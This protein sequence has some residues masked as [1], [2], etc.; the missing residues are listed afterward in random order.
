MKCANHF[1]KEAITKCNLCAKPLCDECVVKLHEESYCR[2]CSTAKTGA[3]SGV[4]KQEHSPAL[5]AIL[6]FIIAGLGQMYNGQVWKGLFVFLTSLLV[7]PWVFGIFD[8]YFVAKKIASGERELKKKTGCLIAMIIWVFVSWVMIF[9]LA[10]LAAIV[11]PNLLRARM[12]TDEKSVV[13]TLQS[14]SSAFESYAAQNN[15]IYTL[16]EETLITTQPQYLPA[17]YNNRTLYGYKLT[18]TLRTSGYS[19]KAEPV[20]CLPGGKIFIMETGGKLSQ[21]ECRPSKDNG[22]DKE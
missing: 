21:E 10:L 19:I 14:I 22:A 8:A 7:I 12:I 13:S 20:T 9:V 17:A 6:S 18:E 11:I 3:I 5:A 2:P 4:K 16:S 1:E 15:K